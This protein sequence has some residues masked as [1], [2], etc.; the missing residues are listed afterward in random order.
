[1][2]GD[3]IGIGW[4]DAPPEAI[5]LETM[6]G[7]GIRPRTL[8]VDL[9]HLSFVDGERMTGVGLILGS[10]RTAVERVDGE[11]PDGAILLLARDGAIALAERLLNAVQAIDDEAGET[12]AE[13][14]DETPS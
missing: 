10:P 1:M 8:R 7:G 2:S 5:N 4:C 14:D 13:W 6:D 3:G 11:R 12:T 9:G